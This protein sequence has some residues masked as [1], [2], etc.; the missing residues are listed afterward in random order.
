MHEIAFRPKA[1]D[2]LRFVGRC[3]VEGTRFPYALQPGSSGSLF[4]TCFTLLIAHL[5]DARGQIKDCPRAVDSIRSVES[6]DHDLIINPD[7][8][9]ADLMKPAV[10]SPEYLALQSTSFVHAA[11]NAMGSPPR[12]PIRWVVNV[13]ERMGVRTWLDGLPWDNPW[14]ASNL[15]MFLGDFLLEWRHLAPADH[16]V[17]S[18]IHQYFE[19]HN[20]HQDA[21]TGFWGST[22]DLLN[23]MAG[24]YHLVLHYDYAEEPLR[25]REA[26]I[27]AVLTLAWRDGLFVYG[28][29]GGSCEDLDAIDLLVRLSR[30]CDHRAAKVRSVLL[31]A[32][33]R[34][35]S[36][37]NADGGYGWRIVPQPRRAFTALSNG[38]RELASDIGVSWLYAMKVRSHLRSTHYYSSCRAYPYRVDRSDTWSTWFRPQALLLIARRY[39]E[40]FTDVP[41][42]KLPTWPGLGFD[43]WCARPEPVQRARQVR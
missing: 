1:S 11:L 12:R 6:D 25:H 42:W 41:D 15:D 39:P 24:A 23:A 33:R 9:A 16:R 36:G 5:L 43:P 21:Q 30:G 31:R 10:H 26:M 37:D 20:E 14:L 34:I 35:A 28:G 17:V 29:G 32:A 13:V 27:D 18:A 40:A 7:F 8:S 4:G 38:D 2:I 22:S 3:H 19:W